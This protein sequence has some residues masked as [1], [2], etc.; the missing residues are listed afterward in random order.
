[1]GSLGSLPVR[2]CQ[3]T[4]LRWAGPVD[5]LQPPQICHLEQRDF[6]TVRG[7]FSFLFLCFGNSF[8]LIQAKTQ[9]ALVF[10]TLYFPR[11]AQKSV[12]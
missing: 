5:N 4:T 1:V 2:D 9:N 8:V 7:A 10:E 12:K 6:G 3:Q 11:S